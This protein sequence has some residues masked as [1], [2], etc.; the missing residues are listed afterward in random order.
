MGGA[1]LVLLVLEVNDTGYAYLFCKCRREKWHEMD[2]MD[3]DSQSRSL[4]FLMKQ[5]ATFLFLLFLIITCSLNISSHMR[6][7][8]SHLQWL[9]PQGYNIWLTT[10]MLN[11]HLNWNFFF[12]LLFQIAFKEL[13]FFMSTIPCNCLSEHVTYLAILCHYYSNEGCILRCSIII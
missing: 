12:K 7:C 3:L 8:V 11:H 6:T 9:F 10:R 2:G 13:Q 5:I 1:L 4:G